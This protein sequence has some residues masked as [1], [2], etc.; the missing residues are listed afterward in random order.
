M[1]VYKE[2]NTWRAVSL[3]ELAGAEKT[4]AE[5]RISDKTGSISL[6]TGAA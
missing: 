6:E 3:Y 2:G 1:A 5:K 4:N